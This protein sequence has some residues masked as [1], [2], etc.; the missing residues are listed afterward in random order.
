MFF[1]LYS[2]PFS[3]HGSNMVALIFLVSSVTY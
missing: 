3:D 1:P 2:H